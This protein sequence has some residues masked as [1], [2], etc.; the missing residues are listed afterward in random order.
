M[1]IL[2]MCKP[3]T[4]IE[5]DENLE[6]LLAKDMKPR[7]EIWENLGFKFENSEEDAVVCE[8]KLPE[9]WTIVPI[10]T[11]KYEI[12][13]ANNLTRAKMTYNIKINTAS[14]RLITRYGIHSSYEERDTVDIFGRK[15]KV[16][17]KVVYFG[18]EEERI[19]VAGEA[20]FEDYC[21][22]EEINEFYNDKNRLEKMAN[23][24]GDKNY[25]DWKNLMAYWEEEP[26]KVYEKAN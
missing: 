22:N 5:S 10:E 25:P 4:P 17:V 24:Y 20:Q 19:Y 3:K 15:S 9:G 14:M 18:T 7:R 26:K 1:T 13:D 8:A 11:Y 16:R 6:I 21:S 12:K 23:E 2:G